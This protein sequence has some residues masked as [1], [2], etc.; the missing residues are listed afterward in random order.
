[1]WNVKYHID[2]ELD[3][4]RQVTRRDSMVVDV[5]TSDDA[6]A[7]ILDQFENSDDLLVEMGDLFGSIRSET[8]EIDECSKITSE[9]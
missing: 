1:M 5:D 4:G 3:D 8:L 9:S 7:M 6:E 2:F